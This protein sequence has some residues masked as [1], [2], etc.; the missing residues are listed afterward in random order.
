MLTEYI[1]NYVV[2]VGSGGGGTSDNSDGGDSLVPSLGSA[3]GR[4]RTSMLC[5]YIVGPFKYKGTYKV[6]GPLLQKSERGNKTV[7]CCWE[8][9]NLSTSDVYYIHTYTCKRCI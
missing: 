2:M 6:D 9:V 3:M 1:I 4:G 8:G 5:T 7:R